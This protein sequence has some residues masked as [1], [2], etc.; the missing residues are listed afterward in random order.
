MTP[1]E[2]VAAL[3]S[4]LGV[5]LT[6]RRIMLCWPVMLAASILYGMVF[7]QARLYADTALQGVFAALSLYGWWRWLRGME[8][9]GTVTIKALSKSALWIGLGASAAGGMALGLLLR[10]TTDDPMPLLDALLSAYS[11][12]GQIWM[13]RR[14]VASWWVWIVVDTLY[15]GL[16]LVRELYLTAA[17]YAAFVVLAATGLRQWRRVGTMADPARD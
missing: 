3:M 1:L 5:W 8:E 11:I 13:A 10:T 14:H 7:W 15:T 12:L 4:A 17:L 6:G 9:K 2:T 16:F